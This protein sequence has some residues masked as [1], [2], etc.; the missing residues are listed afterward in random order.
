MFRLSFVVFRCLYGSSNNW[1]ALGQWTPPEDRGLRIGGGLL[2]SF[3][4]TI[5]YLFLPLRV[6]ISCKIALFLKSL[7]SSSISL[8]FC[9]QDHHLRLLRYLFNRDVCRPSDFDSLDTTTSSL[10]RFRENLLP[11]EN[12]KHSF[13]SILHS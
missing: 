12:L 7:R 5:Q 1:Y 10:F 8:L 4:I 6:K 3:F 11:Y 9:F 2:A 13:S